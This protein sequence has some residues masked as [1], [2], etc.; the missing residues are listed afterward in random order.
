MPACRTLLEPEGDQA[1]ADSILIHI[2]LYAAELCTSRPISEILG[3]QRVQNAEQGNL[4]D[5]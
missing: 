2:L 1:D 4:T 3:A 5:P